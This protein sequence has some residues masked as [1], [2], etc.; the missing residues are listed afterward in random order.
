MTDYEVQRPAGL[1]E[2]RCIVRDTLG[3][4]GTIAAC[5]TYTDS[6][7]SNS[8][9][10]V[11]DIVMA[12]KQCVAEH[13][14]LTTIVLDTQTDSPL[15]ARQA[16][17]SIS[18]HLRISSHPI[19]PENAMAEVLNQVHNDPLDDLSTHPPW[20][21]YIRM[22]KTSSALRTFIAAFAYSHA[23]ADGFS[24]LLF[25]RSFLR[26]LCGTEGLPHTTDANFVPETSS[27]LFPALEQAATLPIS[28]SFLLGP[29]IA[30]YCPGIL[31]RALAR[32]LQETGQEDPRLFKAETAIDLR[33]CIPA[34][35]DT[36][37][38]FPS[39]VTDVVTTSNTKATDTPLTK[40][41]W[42]TAQR[43]THRLQEASSTLSDQPVGLLKYLSDF[44]SW[45]IKKASQPPE[46]SFSVSNLGV[47]ETETAKADGES[48]SGGGWVIG[49]MAFSQ[50]ADATGAAFNLNLASTKAGGLNVV[51]TWWPGMLGVQDEGR[52]MERVCGGVV[53]QMEHIAG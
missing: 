17:M 50:S 43:L 15:L 34:A 13:P 27:R 42:Q 32:S 9:L 6:G 29:L 45:T 5:A 16:N 14:V 40:E 1:N 30:E 51:V 35:K 20:R 41:D 38:N 28:W 36:M 10:P 21:L 49:D 23:I 8:N 12:L 37:G 22:I 33:R 26:A 47:F 24:G 4:Y 39:A 48:E 2:L 19:S 44:R 52:L 7:A 11:D 31:K 53:D 18:H 46:C 3:L 25:H